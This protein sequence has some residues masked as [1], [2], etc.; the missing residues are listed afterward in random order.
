MGVRSRWPQHSARVR[1]SPRWQVLRFAAKRRDSW[2]CVQCG[3]RHKLEVDHIKPVRTHPELAYVLD[4]LQTLCTSCHTRKTR[5]E[6]GHDPLNPLREA[7]RS[8]V[9]STVTK[10][11]EYVGIR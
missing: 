1:K 8:L 5:L 4:N 2:K 10:E 11:V 7:W 6:C 9:R 3:S